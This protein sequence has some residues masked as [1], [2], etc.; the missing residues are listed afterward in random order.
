EFWILFCK[1][2]ETHQRVLNRRLTGLHL[3]VTDIR[4]LHKSICSLILYTYRGL[5]LFNLS[6]ITF[7]TES[8]H[9]TIDEVAIKP[10]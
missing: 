9:Y 2:V 1:L 8:E 4:S 3:C 10:M 6:Y 7:S 5:A